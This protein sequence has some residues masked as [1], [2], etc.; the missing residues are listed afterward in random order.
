MLELA[1]AS[2][3]AK[4]RGE[5]LTDRLKAIYNGSNVGKSVVSDMKSF[6]IKHRRLTNIRRTVGELSAEDRRNVDSAGLILLAKREEDAILEKIST[7]CENDFIYSLIT[8]EVVRAAGELGELELN[9][10][11]IF[12]KAAETIPP[13][14]RFEHEVNGVHPDLIVFANPAS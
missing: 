12:S 3:F 11:N 4:K 6:Y 9:V 7:S 13:I 2:E 1:P 10:G 14:V 8:S 5:E